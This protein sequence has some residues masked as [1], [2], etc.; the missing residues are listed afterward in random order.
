[1]SPRHGRYVST[2][3]SMGFSAAETQRRKS[4]VMMPDDLIPPASRK[5]FPV[6]FLLG[7]CS[8]AFSAALRAKP[9]F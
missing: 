4:T 1:M 9:A 6:S 8:F 5:T 2:D 7:E 3:R